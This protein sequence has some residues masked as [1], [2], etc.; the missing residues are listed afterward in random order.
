MSLKHK[1]KDILSKLFGELVP[2]HECIS[3]GKEIADGTAFMLCDNCKSEITW[4]NGKVCSKCGD[5]LPEN[6]S[7]ICDNCKDKDYFFDSNV[8]CCYY[9][10]KSAA[11]VKGLKYGN[12]KYYAKYIAKIMSLSKSTFENIDII[13]FVPVSKKRR[14]ER[15]YNQSEE[16]AKCL[17][18]IV[19]IE[20]KNLLVKTFDGKHQAKLSQAERL[21]N[22]AGS[23]ELADGADTEIKGKHILIV[24]DVFTTGTTLNE[25][26]KVLKKAKPKKIASITFTKTKLD[27]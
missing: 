6:G 24:D 4:L 21:K 22:L 26:S 1:I 7:M 14:R 15:G 2:E 25:C 9:S 20:V 3:C 18:E 8:S 5:K 12:R 16:I 19:N 17:G 27:S 13:T 11:I 23:F 10:E